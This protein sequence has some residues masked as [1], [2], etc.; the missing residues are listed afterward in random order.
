MCVRQTMF[1]AADLR[2]AGLDEVKLA[3]LLN[4]QTYKDFYHDFR[5][6]SHE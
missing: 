4:T 5:Q 3:A 6:K 1:L 2:Q